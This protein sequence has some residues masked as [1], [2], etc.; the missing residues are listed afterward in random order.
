MIV[1]F[2]EQLKGLKIPEHWIEAKPGRF[3]VY[4]TKEEIK[5]IAKEKF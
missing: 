2:Q 1:P 5:E 4:L 3:A